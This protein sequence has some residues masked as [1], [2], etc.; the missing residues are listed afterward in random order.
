M[1]WIRID[2]CSDYDPFLAAGV[3]SRAIAAGAGGVKSVEEQAMFGREAGVAYD[4]DY[5]AAGDH[6]T[7]LNLGYWVQ[8]TK[9]LAHLTATYARGFDS[10]LAAEKR[11]YEGQEDGSSEEEDE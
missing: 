8:M 9:A 4:I 2:G 11:S 10:L 3:A 5:H 1:R 6:V 7:N